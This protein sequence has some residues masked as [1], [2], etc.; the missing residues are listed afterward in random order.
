MHTRTDNGTMTT[1]QA[2]QY[3][4]AA[5]KL[6]STC[7]ALSRDRHDKYSTTRDIV[8]FN[9]HQESKKMVLFALDNLR[10]AWNFQK[11][12]HINMLTSFGVT[13]PDGLLPEP[14]A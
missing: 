6:Y 3:V 9:Q 5:R 11:L 12:A 7:C 10:N 8:Y 14:P 4:K 1:E 2:R 13:T